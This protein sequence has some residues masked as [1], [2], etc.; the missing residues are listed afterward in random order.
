MNTKRLKDNFFVADLTR[1]LV[2]LWTEDD[3][4]FLP[5]RYRLHT[6]QYPMIWSPGTRSARVQKEQIFPDKERYLDVSYTTTLPLLREIFKKTEAQAKAFSSVRQGKD[7]R[8]IVDR[9]Q[10]YQISPIHYQTIP[11]P[12]VLPSRTK[13]L[14]TVPFA[15]ELTLIL[16]YLESRKLRSNMTIDSSRPISHLFLQS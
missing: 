2:T 8:K 16:L 3:L 15:Q 4:I 14:Y 6:I 5:E 1:V 11:H 12:L 13:P 7:V 10:R 9:I